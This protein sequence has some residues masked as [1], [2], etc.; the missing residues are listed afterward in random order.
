M[1]GKGSRNGAEMREKMRANCLSR[2]HLERR[3]RGL[4]KLV[5]HTKYSFIAAPFSFG[6]MNDA[7]AA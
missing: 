4:C 3:D 7:S 1:E 5:I 2:R 6:G